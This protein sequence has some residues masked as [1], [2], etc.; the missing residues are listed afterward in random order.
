MLNTHSPLILV[1]HSDIS[2]K[3]KSDGL[4]SNNFTVAPLITV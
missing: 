3:L 1:T 2:I 4:Y